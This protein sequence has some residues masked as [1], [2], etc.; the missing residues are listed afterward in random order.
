MPPPTVA[1]SSA[2][3][4]ADVPHP[5]LPTAPIRRARSGRGIA[6]GLVL[7][8]LA[9]RLL[10]D[11]PRWHP[12]AGIGRAIAVLEQQLYGDSHAR[13]AGLTGLSVAAAWGIGALAT[14]RAGARGTVL[15]TATTTWA[16]L[17]GTTLCR[18][19]V[20]MAD[21]LD[22]GDLDAARRLVPSLCGRD[23]DALDEAGMIRAAVES[24]AEN[25]SDAAVAPL[26]WGAVA[27]VPGLLAYRTAN[28]LDAMVGYRN[29]R[30]QRFGWASAR[31]DDLANL[32]PA[33]LSGLLVVALGG[34]PTRTVATW[35]R[36]AGRHPSPN[37]GVV[38]SAFAGAI[39]VRLG[40]RTEYRHG[41]ENR[42]LLGTGAAPTTTDLRAAVHLSRRVQVGAALTSAMIAILVNRRSGD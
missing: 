9:D 26:L 11:P 12:V 6:S 20:A 4:I 16:V 34:A 13:G 22:A 3:T 40:G 23:P 18:V 2:D 42:P 41:V 38:E 30:Y 15:V 5:S 1:G 29:P 39:G 21:A 27:G 28:T 19:G 31:L 8:A 36:D 17:G 10:G 7:G 24:I 32:V 25:T 14:R 33:R 37:A 35:R